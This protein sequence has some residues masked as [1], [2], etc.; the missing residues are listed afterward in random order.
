MIVARLYGM[1]RVVGMCEGGFSIPWVYQG[2]QSSVVQYYDYVVFLLFFWMITCR[3]HF[4]TI[5][6]DEQEIFVYYQSTCRQASILLYLLI[7]QLVE[8]HNTFQSVTLNT[9]SSVHRIDRCDFSFCN[10][11]KHK[12][13]PLKIS[14][15]ILVD[16]FYTIISNQPFEI[17]ITCFLEQQHNNPRFCE[18]QKSVI[19]LF[20]QSSL[21]LSTVLQPIG[22]NNEV[23]DID[24]Q[25][26]DEF[27]EKVVNHPEVIFDYWN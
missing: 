21:F 7:G 6:R 16:Y 26:I 4:Y 8:G 17:T 1:N 11:H 27:E 23:M 22:L 9:Y 10:Y 5:L 12:N 15:S 13:A 19:L 20:S 3:Y 2:L 24:K 18:F 14:I 25:I